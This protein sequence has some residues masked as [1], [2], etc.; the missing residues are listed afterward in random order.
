MFLF[1]LSPFLPAKTE[2]HR[3]D[4]LQAT[5][6]YFAQFRDKILAYSVFGG[7][8]F[9]SLSPCPYMAKGVSEISLISF[10]RRSFIK[11]ISFIKLHHQVLFTS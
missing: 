9:L 11:L 8:Y 3:L 1:F 6:V 5:K 2:Y 7:G 10:K 4:G